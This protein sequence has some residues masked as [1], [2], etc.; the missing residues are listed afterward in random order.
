MSRKKGLRHKPR[1]R[2]QVVKRS[3]CGGKKLV[4]ITTHQQEKNGGGGG[5]VCRVRGGIDSNSMSGRSCS[6]TS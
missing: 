6:V 3:A 4:I 1:L 2:E 5:R